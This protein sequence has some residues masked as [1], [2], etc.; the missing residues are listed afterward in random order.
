MKINRI[1]WSNFKSLT[2]GSI[3]ADG[4]NVTITGRNGAGKSS[5][6]SILPFI[7]FGKVTGSVK[8]YDDGSAPQDDGLIHAA[9]VSFDDGSTLR[10]EYFWAN[11]GNHFALYINGKK[12]SSSNF[13]SSV[14]N[15]THGAG[16]FVFNP[17][18]FCNLDDAEQRDILTYAFATVTDADLLATEFPELRE[19]LDGQSVDVFIN[20]TKN[21]LKS[22]KTKTAAIPGQIE[23]L[24]R[25]IDT[26]DIDAELH[27]VDDKLNA[28]QSERAQLS[29]CPTNDPNLELARLQ[30]QVSEFK[31]RK[32][33]VQ[34]EIDRLNDE[35][36]EL[37]TEYVEIQAAAGVCPTC[38]Q[39]LPADFQK[40]RAAR[41]AAIVER[42]LKY[43]SEVERREKILADIGTER[44][45][46][47]NQ[48]AQLRASEQMSAAT[49]RR[50]RLTALDNEIYKLTTRKGY[51]Q[52]QTAILNQIQTLRERERDLNQQILQIDSQL[53]DAKIFT[54][55]K[56]QLVED[57]I[58]S[59][60][61]HVHFKL[62]DYLVTT[63]EVRPTC[64]ATL[65][66]VPYSALSKGEK[67]RAALDIFRALQ[68]AFNVELPVMLDDAESYTPNSLI[69]IPNQIFAFKV[70]DDD[71]SV[72]VNKEAQ[73]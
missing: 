1:S 19:H 68:R 37:R 8:C 54:W 66:G 18:A 16:E 27:T 51:L 59:H 23:V 73:S 53:N 12:V 26:T 67:L 44:G 3:D 40:K 55:R 47:E 42:G 65:N 35:L 4:H 20:R 10:R 71:L 33:D 24:Q 31:R 15:L 32:I 17:F 9:V 22:L 14:N 70:T 13:K 72:T 2:D 60:F 57:S 34:D 62:F 28:A 21:T 61:E 63:G 25:Q 29:N 11:G 49:A 46:V 7:L 48:I 64:E 38:G 30:K 43:K 52:S 6:A 36:A 41:L 69:N 58:D 45:A 50:E 56:I 39:A 5:I